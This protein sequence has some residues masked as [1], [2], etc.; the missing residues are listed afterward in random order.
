MA[1]TPVATVASRSWA[2]R[3]PRAPS[4]A[5]PATMSS[6]PMGSVARPR[7]A[8]TRGFNVVPRLSA[9]AITAV[10]KPDISAMTAKPDCNVSQNSQLTSRQGQACA[11]PGPHIRW[12]LGPAADPW[13]TLWKAD[14]LPCLLTSW[15]VSIRLQLKPLHL[16]R[17]RFNIEGVGPAT[18]SWARAGKYVT[19][20]GR[21]SVRQSH[22]L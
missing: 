18:P 2:I 19:A 5:R 7:E 20:G 4:E 17:S 22:T 13:L 11:S 6:S 1:Q 8:G 12:A 10:S 21:L 16:P 9:M 14:L 15:R 3:S